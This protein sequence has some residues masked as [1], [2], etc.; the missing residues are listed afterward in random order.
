MLSCIALI[1]LFFI[2][3]NISPKVSLINT[4]HLDHLYKEIDLNDEKSAFIY[5]Y[6]DWPSYNP[7]E[8]P[9]EGI[10]CVDDVARAAVFYFR[11]YNRT[12]DKTYL[13][14]AKKLIYFI[15]S[16]QAENG[17]YYNFINSDHTINKTHINSQA[18]ADW[19][20]WRAMWALAEAM[21]YAK[22]ID[23]SFYEELDSAFTRTLNTLT[24]AGDGHA[25]EKIPSD[26][27]SVFLM[28]LT[29]YYGI[30]RNKTIIDYISTV[31][32][33]IRQSQR[34]DKERFPHYA[35]LS[36]QNIWHGWGNTQA[37]T[38][39]K[40]GKILD[41]PDLIKAAE[42]EIT[43]FYSY[44]LAQNH[45]KQF[46]LDKNGA[47]VDLERFEQIAYA[48]RPMVWASLELYN[49]TKDSVYA[50][51][52]GKMAG[53]LFGENIASSVIYDP[54]SGR[55]YD[56]INSAHDVNLNS[57]AESTIEAL[58]IILEVEKIPIANEYLQSVY[59]KTLNE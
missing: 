52:A 4:S 27:A 8:A 59:R 44:L 23:T 22:N 38:L 18:K 40:A 15:L 57:G 24:E 53:W 25:L 58:L 30:S 17:Y 10:A 33:S 35:F 50:V 20:T 36:W 29:T 7:V 6:A 42:N 32:N 51:Q 3:P 48:V 54:E 16:L 39:L 49:I 56:G 55:C 28:A 31:A 11:Y 9:G 34:G 21:R 43:Y 13:Q 2:G 14:K 37:Y 45:L 19:W 1:F 46:K 12:S 5:I 26:Q 41:D 47:V